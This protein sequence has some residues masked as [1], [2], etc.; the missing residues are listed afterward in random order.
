MLIMAIESSCDETASAVVRDGEKILSSVVASQTELHSRY[1]GVVPELASRA[2][3]ESVFPVTEKALR[4]AGKTIDDID[5]VAVTYGPGLVGSLLVG[6]SFAKALAYSRGIPLIPVNHLEG[7][8]LS[9]I[10]GHGYGSTDFPYI[11]LVVS[12]GHTNIYLVRAIGDYKLL[13]YTVDDA[14]GEAF[15][16]VA[17]MLG[18]GYPGGPVIDEI[19]REGE[20]GVI[21]FPRPSVRGKKYCFSF[22]GLKTAVL[23]HIKNEGYYDNE[24]QF[25]LCEKMKR[26]FKA[27]VALSFQEAAVD[28]LVKKT[29]SAAKKYS[30]KM[31]SIAGGVACNSALR[32]AFI[33]AGEK[34]GMETSIPDISYC[35]D[36]A[37]MI[38]IAGYYRYRNNPVN[39]PLSLNADP[40]ARL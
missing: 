19:A 34:E 2:H 9:G 38:G 7:H 12:G 11:T 14:A 8:L 3:I 26:Q 23:T 1:G 39:A 13:G 15:D 5:A 31:I 17:K 10:I 33:Q 35:M 16:K 20:K 22:S 28:V 18:L 24:K 37:A 29:L 25:P 27:D 6:L 36:N 30:C 40:R 21:K 32:S 4:D